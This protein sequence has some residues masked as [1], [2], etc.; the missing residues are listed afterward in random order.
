MAS[1]GG[2]PLYL[3]D[4]ARGISADTLSA[5]NGVKEVTIMGGK[6]VVSPG[7]EAELKERYGDTG[8]RRLSGVDRYA[9]AA[10]A[11]H[12]SVSSADLGLS[13]NGVGVTTGNNFPDALA[14]GVVQGK[15][16]T[17][18]LLTPSKTLAAPAADKLSANKLK[19]DFVVYYGGPTAVTD[20]VR[21][22]VSTLVK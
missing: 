17:V 20:G 4:P 12:Y 3:V 5:M 16:G 22:A 2:W 10:E 21:K 11:A 1:R 19:I 8:V 9:T 14:G 13:W 18:M 15:R 7:V 6:A